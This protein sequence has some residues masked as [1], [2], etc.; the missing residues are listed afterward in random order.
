MILPLFIFSCEKKSSVQEIDV[1][2]FESKV[3]QSYPIIW[4]QGH[5]IDLRTNETIGYYNRKLY[6]NWLFTDCMLPARNCLPTAFIDGT[7]AKI[8]DTEDVPGYIDTINLPSDVIAL[9]DYQY[10][11]PLEEALTSGDEDEILNFFNEVLVPGTDM[12]QEL[13][14]DFNDGILTIKE[15]PEGHFIVNEDAETSD[16]IIDYWAE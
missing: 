14:D 11:V 15:F 13:I 4:Y 16:D 9:I 7:I 3:Q 10:S 2:E 6:D 5:V 12:P 1:D 8:E